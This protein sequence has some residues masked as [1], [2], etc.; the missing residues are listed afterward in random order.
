MAFVA[1]LL[2][3]V[4]AF[5]LGAVI[6]RH[7]AGDLPEI[8][9]KSVLTPFRTKQKKRPRSISDDEIVKREKNAP[10]ADPT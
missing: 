8:V 4:L 1:G 6:G 10:P 5:L 3:G 2:S 9:N 7:Y